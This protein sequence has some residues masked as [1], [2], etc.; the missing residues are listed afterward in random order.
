MQQVVVDNSRLLRRL[1]DRVMIWFRSSLAPKE[2]T[3]AM[4]AQVEDAPLTL[5]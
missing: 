3:R 2:T 5:G 1:Y 4:N